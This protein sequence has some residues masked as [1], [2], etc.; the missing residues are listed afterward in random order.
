MTISGEKWRLVKRFGLSPLTNER[1]M[2][3]RTISRQCRERLLRQAE[4]KITEEVSTMVQD[5]IDGLRMEASR[6]REAIRLQ[7]ESAALILDQQ[8]RSHQRAIEKVQTKTDFE[9]AQLNENSRLAIATAESKAARYQRQVCS[10]ETKLG[11]FQIVSDRDQETI[12]ELAQKQRS[13]VRALEK[14]KTSAAFETSQLNEGALLAEEKAN[15][16]VYQ[17]RRQVHSIETKLE[18]LKVV[19][20]RDQKTMR[21]LAQQQRSHNR[22]LEKMK[23]T[24]AYEI[25]QLMESAG[26][27]KKRRK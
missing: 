13:H 27:A 18:E 25:S 6:L 19:L 26:L 7:E 9:I 12:R 21:E 3:M 15:E 8:K 2:N 22:A 16:N 17:H 5:E 14:M 23:T 11:E 1:R 20:D 4:R 10:Y 24:G